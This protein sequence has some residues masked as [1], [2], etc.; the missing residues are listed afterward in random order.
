MR[1]KRSSTMR[2]ALNNSSWMVL[3]SIL[4]GVSLEFF[5]SKAASK[6]LA[7]ADPSLLYTLIG[8]LFSVGVGLSVSFSY[9]DIQDESFYNDLNNDIKK[10]TYTFI[11]LFFLS[12]FIFFIYQ[13]N[14]DYCLQT[15]SKTQLL[16]LTSSIF[17]LILVVLWMAVMFLGIYKIK[18]D[19]DTERRKESRK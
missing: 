18:S 4:L 11:S 9:N 17:F 15:I 2:K 8:I 14:K 16:L 7:I 3:A 10:I 12:T 6:L 19:L 13:S 1:K 5:A